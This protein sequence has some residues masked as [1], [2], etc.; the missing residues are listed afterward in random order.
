MMAIRKPLVRYPVDDRTPAGILGPDADA[1]L[2][3]RT[4][5]HAP[6]RGR[7]RRTAARRDPRLVALGPVPRR[8]ARPGRPAPADRR[9]RPPRPRPVAR[10]ARAVRAPR[11]RR[12]CG[13]AA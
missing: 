2:P 12:G 8:R 10:R 9:P 1:P 13:G 7:R 11:P 4:G 3:G 5:A 6:L